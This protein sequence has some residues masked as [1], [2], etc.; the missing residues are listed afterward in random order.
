MLGNSP[1]ISTQNGDIVGEG[2]CCVV[3][4]VV[5]GESQSINLQKKVKIRIF[6]GRLTSY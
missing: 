1:S 6:H 5:D 4:G 2:I 3:E